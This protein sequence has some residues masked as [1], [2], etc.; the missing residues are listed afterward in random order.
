MAVGKWTVKNPITVERFIQDL[1]NGAIGVETVLA[2][3]GAYLQTEMKKITQEDDASGRLTASITWQTANKGSNV[4]GKG[5]N[6][7]DTI[8]KPSAPFTL[9]VGSAAPHAIYRE[10]YSGTHK[11]WE[12]HEEF[13][14]LMK[15]WV[16][17]KYD[18]PFNPDSGDPED[19]ELFE[20]I[21]DVV[22]RHPTLGVP[23]VL[24]TLPKVLPF[25]MK[26]LRWAI[27]KYFKANGGTK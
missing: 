20:H 4:G 3:T 23:F 9:I 26:R 15:I 11:T 1:N 8:A 25:A 21:L 12:G 14:A 16:Q 24:P 27:M 5:A 7:K 19:A 10:K 22:R 6:K 13:V 17:T 18:K 2:S